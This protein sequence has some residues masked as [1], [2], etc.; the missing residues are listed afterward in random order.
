MRLNFLFFMVVLTLLAQR[1][2]RPGVKSVQRPMSEITPD[3]VFQIEG[4]P[5]WSVITPDGLWVSNGPKNTVHKLNAKTNQVE[6]TVTVGSR[7]CS[8]IAYG[9]GSVWVPNC[10][11]KTVSRVDATTNKVIATINA[12][13]AN[14]EGGI[15]CSDDAVWL[16]T[17]GGN[18]I[19]R[20]DPKT[21]SVAAEIETADGSYA[22]T[23]GE[24]AVWVSSTKNNLVSRIDPAVNK[25]TDQVAVGPQPRFLTA[26][27]GYVWTLNQGDGTVSKIDPASRKTIANIEVGIPGGGGEV[28]T[29]AGSVWVTVFEIPIS[30]IDA[31]SGRV[32]HQWAG[33]GGDA[34]RF[35]HGSVW[36][37]NLRQQN[38]WRISLEKLS[39]PGP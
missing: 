3:A 15:A 37:S 30:R 39:R 9:F 34:I 8:G 16:P 31:R 33:P 27:E 23:F 29:G 20:I 13:P 10:G 12:G 24:G 1:P 35:G 4:V 36:L 21:N 11:D 6:A 25:V 19:A 18:K 17:G 38:V 28:G 2:P 7:P 5:D 22:A 14:S 26:G 32:T